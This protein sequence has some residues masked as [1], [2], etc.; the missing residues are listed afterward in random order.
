M[1][2]PTSILP[3]LALALAA[4]GLLGLSIPSLAAP[5]WSQITPD[6]GAVHDD[7][8]SAVAIS[9]PLVLVGSP[10]DDGAGSE[11]GSAHLF[12]RRAGAW[13]EI[14]E[15]E[16]TEPAGAPAFGH[17]VALDRRVLAIGA[18]GRFASGASA[19][20]F[21]IYRKGGAR[22]HPEAVLTGSDAL[23]GSHFGV[24]VAIEG[25]TLV[26]GAPGTT[27]F[28]GVVG[29]VYLFERQAG[30]WQETAK[31]ASPIADTNGRFGASVALDRG[32]LVVGAPGESHRREGGDTGTAYVYRRDDGGWAGP[33][34][35][36]GG[37]PRSQVFGGSVDVSGAWIAVG[38][39]AVGP[40]IAG[41][42]SA[43]YLFARRG[44]AWVPAAR[45]RPETVAP[46]DRFGVPLILEGRKLF[47][48]APHTPIPGDS[49]HTILGRGLVYAFRLQKGTWQEG[50]LLRPPGTANF[51]GAA[52]AGSPG[53]LVVGAPHPDPARSAAYVLRA[54]R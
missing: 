2:A 17:A 24:S 54:P 30:E 4:P 34:I 3:V 53:G 5:P 50:N 23:L 14:Q 41:G 32:T 11:A 16:P 51:F 35:L 47:V 20:S 42:E 40:G 31:L 29:A 43:V 12:V 8:G 13:R 1:R 18:P 15:L 33:E 25:E 9:G 21:E 46:G 37:D 36:R 22:W 48:G 27:T 7:F 6:G 26:V 49:P 10:G 19:G 44:G 38:A 52:L 39:T 45:L 28:P